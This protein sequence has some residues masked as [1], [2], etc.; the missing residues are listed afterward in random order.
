MTTPPQGPRVV[1]SHWLPALIFAALAI[2]PWL[3]QLRWR[4]TLRTLLIA[5]TLVAALL[6]LVTWLSR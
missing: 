5:T 4:F 2:V 6:G 1:I 3:R